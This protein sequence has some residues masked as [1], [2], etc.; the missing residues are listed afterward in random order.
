MLTEIQKL[1]F[2]TVKI[3]FNWYFIEN[4]FNTIYSSLRI[5]AF[6]RIQKLKIVATF[7]FLF[8]IYIIFYV[9]YM[10]IVL[11]Y[12]KIC[13]SCLLIFDITNILLLFLGLKP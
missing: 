13:V 2:T 7:L 11:V 8:F 12:I 10:L 6:K 3:R 1:G 9:L 5:F 4:C